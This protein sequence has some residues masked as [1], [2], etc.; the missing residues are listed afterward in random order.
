MQVNNTLAYS[1]MAV[2]YTS[3]IF[4]VFAPDN[5]CYTQIR[6]Q[7]HMKFTVVSYECS[8]SI[9][10]IHASKQCRVLKTA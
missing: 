9:H 3:R 7:F 5:R 1:A 4:K 8:H 6:D 10:C 2:N